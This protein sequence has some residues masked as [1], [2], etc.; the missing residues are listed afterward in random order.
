MLELYLLI[1]MKRLEEKERDKYNFQMVFAGSHES[2]PV[3]PQCFTLRFEPAAALKQVLSTLHQTAEAQ[4]QG[5]E[6]DRLSRN[7]SYESRCRYRFAAA[8]FGATL[9]HL[10]QVLYG[11]FVPSLRSQAKLCVCQAW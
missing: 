9:D 10:A 2:P 5:L 3:W 7:S 6:F 8:K 4:F 1:A 11:I